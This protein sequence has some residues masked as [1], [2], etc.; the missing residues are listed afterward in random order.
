M[1]P[2]SGCNRSQN[3]SVYIYCYIKMFKEAAAQLSSLIQHHILKPGSLKY[4]VQKPLL[5]SYKNCIW[6]EWQYNKKHK[7]VKAY[8]KPAE[9]HLC[10]D[11]QTG[12]HLGGKLS[13]LGFVHTEDA[14]KTVK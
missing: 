1:A 8:D 3:Y 7:E 10:K 14:I 12:A 4:D 13:Y 6:L 5:L 11:D 2:V 9:A